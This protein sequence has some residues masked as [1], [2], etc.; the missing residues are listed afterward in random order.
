MDHP[1]PLDARNKPP[2]DDD[3]TE[4]AP[5][6]KPGLL[7]AI[8]RTRVLPIVAASALPRVPDGYV[9]TTPEQRRK[10]LRVLGADE[11]A[12]AKDA[13]RQL[14]ARGPA[15][16][17]A[18]LGDAGRDVQDAGALLQEFEATDAT[19]KELAA[20]VRYHE[21]RRVIL[22][23]DI[24]QRIDV[25]REEVDHRRKRAPR[26]AETYSAVLAFAAARGARIAAG[27]AR[28]RALD[29]ERAEPP[30]AAPVADDE[31]PEEL[32]P[33]PKPAAKKP[34]KKPVPQ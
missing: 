13:L 28:S 25:A 29:E 4:A 8:A 22:A 34:A 3:A 32:A 23:N 26:L 11:E 31:A 19:L 27:M 7:D 2:T 33:P 1:Y 18:D 16:L 9:P 20:L 10:V 21:E 24:V 5:A 30:P 6:P 17:A 14:A 12:E 15:K